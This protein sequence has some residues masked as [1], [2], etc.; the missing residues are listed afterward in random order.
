MVSFL[1]GW[2]RSCHH[3]VSGA[4]ETQ[5]PT[6]TRSE[7]VAESALASGLIIGQDFAA[8]GK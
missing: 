1:A 7:S 5:N 2:F 4:E 3:G 6:A 8:A